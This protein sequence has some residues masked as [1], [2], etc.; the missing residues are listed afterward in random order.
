[1]IYDAELDAWPVPA[2]PTP[3][4][5]RRR[6]TVVGLMK[7]ILGVAF[8]L[9]MVLVL[10]GGSGER[11]GPARRAQCMNNLK[12][13]GLAL[14]NYQDAFGSLPPA[15]IADAD[16]RPMHSWRVL[17]LPFLDQQRLYDQYNFREPWNG[18][19]NSKLLDRM[20]SVFTCPSRNSYPTSLTSYVAITGPGTMFRGAG[21]SKFTDVS[22]GLDETI[23]VVESLNIVV[24]WTAPTDLDV[25]TI[26]LRIND[27]AYAGISSP[28]PRGANVGFG[29][30][31]VRFVREGISP[32]LL[33]ALFTIAGGEKIDITEAL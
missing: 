30:T 6:I 9:W 3:T 21:S 31:S 13:I 22:D 5:R 15:Y 29:D 12:Q 14:A 4:R 8:C 24:P 33:R 1:M 17:I 32:G 20:P 23:T 19:N 18:P 16:G 25:R 2:G 11:W 10:F 27:P 26:S 7:W 28:H